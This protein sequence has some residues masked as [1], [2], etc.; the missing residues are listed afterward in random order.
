MGLEEFR[1]PDRPLSSDLLNH[2]VCS[3]KHPILVVLCNLRKVLPEGV[4]LV[5]RT[6]AVGS[7]SLQSPGIHLLITHR[8][9]DNLAD[10]GGN[11][12]EVYSF[13]P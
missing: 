12:G 2:I 3:R 7:Q 9:A 8:F 13:S 1:K 5:R 11:F 10:L 4:G 6:W